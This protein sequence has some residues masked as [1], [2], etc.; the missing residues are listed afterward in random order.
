MPGRPVVADLRVCPDLGI[1]DCR[2]SVHV[3][4]K[5]A[6]TGAPLPQIV[7]WFKTMTTNEYLSGEREKS[8]HFSPV[9]LWQRN[10]Y[11]HVIRNERFL[12]NVRE[13]ISTNPV[14]WAKDPE[15]PQQ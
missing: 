4:E 3:P 7:Q 15:N 2:K 8:R 1:S 11:E 5:G 13:Y 6:R 12:N 14:F 10:Y 9:R